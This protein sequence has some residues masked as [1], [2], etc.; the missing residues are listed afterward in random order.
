MALKPCFVKSFLKGNKLSNGLI[1]TQM[2][3]HQQTNQFLQK[4]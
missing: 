4:S 2:K 3:Q 1:N